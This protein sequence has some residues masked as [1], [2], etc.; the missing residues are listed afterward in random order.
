MVINVIVAVRGSV[1]VLA[2]GVI[3]IALVDSSFVFWFKSNKIRVF[4]HITDSTH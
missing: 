1:L 3:V 4:R 2:E